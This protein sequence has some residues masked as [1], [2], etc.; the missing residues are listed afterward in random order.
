M[1]IAKQRRDR[2]SQHKHRKSRRSYKTELENAQILLA[3]E[4]AQLSEGQV[5][6]ILDIDRVS[7]RMM[8]EGAIAEGMNIAAALDARGAK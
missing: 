6:R 8:R 1:S 2:L 3:W 4:A 5:A 7:L